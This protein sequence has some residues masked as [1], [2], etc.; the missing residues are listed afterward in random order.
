MTDA[1]TSFR[2]KDL[3]MAS[4][5]WCQENTKL[6]R[7]DGQKG[8]GNTVFFVFELALTEEQLQQ[9]QIDYA[10]GDTK[11]EPTAFCKRQ[12]QLRD[13]LH[14]SLGSMGHDKDKEKV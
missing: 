12:N 7:T 5:I 6:V 9:L 11:I 14:L 8:R 4:F 10:N 1:Q 3:N 2:T 13:M